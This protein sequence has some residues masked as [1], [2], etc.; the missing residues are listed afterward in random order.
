MRPAIVL[1]LGFPGTGK[2]TVAKE[3][4]SS[5]D[6]DEAPARLIDNHTTANVLFHL[7]AEADGKTPLPEEVLKNDR[8]INQIVLRTIDQLSPPHWSFVF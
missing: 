5:F 3:L 8:E 4:I 1:I 7:I 2:Y 6:S